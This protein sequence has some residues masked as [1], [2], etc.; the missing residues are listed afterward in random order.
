MRS[1]NTYGN[2]SKRLPGRL[3]DAKDQDFAGVIQ[4]DRE[5]PRI[6][7][8]RPAPFAVL[9]VIPNVPTGDPEFDATWIKMN[10]GAGFDPNQAES[11]AN[12]PFITI[13][14]KREGFPSFDTLFQTRGADAELGVNP[15]P[16]STTIPEL[17]VR[18]DHH[19]LGAKSKKGPDG[20]TGRR[21]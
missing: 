14:R 9:Q 17:H 7:D 19:Y 20:G 2:R 11:P 4:T 16:A 15:T 18:A 5:V 1:V 8:N 21:W 3:S 12:R 13:V 6:A 10:N